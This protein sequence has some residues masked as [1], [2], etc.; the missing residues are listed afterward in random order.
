[1]ARLTNMY[2]DYA[3]DR[4]EKRQGMLLSDWVAL[5][6]KWLVFNERDVLRGAG[7]RTKKQAD[8]HARE[9]WEVYNQR[10]DEET[11]AK[12]MADPEAT[13]LEISDK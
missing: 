11:N 12:D 13:V 3:E 9:H 6:D 5:T 8:A 7:S 4:A 10:L 2:L 1:M